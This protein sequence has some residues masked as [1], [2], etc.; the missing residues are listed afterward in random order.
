MLPRRRSTVFVLV[1]WTGS[2]DGML[3]VNHR[4]MFTEHVE[5]PV[6]LTICCHLGEDGDSRVID[7]LLEQT[8]VVMLEALAHQSPLLRKTCCSSKSRGSPSSMLLEC[9]CLELLTP[10]PNSGWT[11][12]R[13]LWSG[14]CCRTPVG[15]ECVGI[16]CW[17]NRLCGFPSWTL[18]GACWDTT[19]PGSMCC[20]CWWQHVAR[21]SVVQDRLDGGTRCC[22]HDHLVPCWHE[23]CPIETVDLTLLVFHCGEHLRCKSKEPLLLAASL[24][25]VGPFL[26]PR[27]SGL[28][29]VEVSNVDF[30]LMLAS[31]RVTAV[32]DT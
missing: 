10:I 30:T 29:T 24:R 23:K 8:P 1:P 4:V 14:S 18:V 26:S 22:E 2:V 27:L 31:A 9:P 5:N 32:G 19:T 25:G 13:P 12:S 16:L 15:V 7:G 21:C 28:T 20:H 11:L 17:R 6:A 3:A